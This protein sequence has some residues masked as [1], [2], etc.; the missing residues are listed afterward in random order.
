MAVPESVYVSV[1]CVCVRG[2]FVVLFEVLFEVL[3]DVLLEVFVHVFLSLAR[4]L[5]LLLPRYLVTT[6]QGR[7]VWGKKKVVRQVQE[8]V[9]SPYW[10][11][12]TFDNMQALPKTKTKTGSAADTSGR[13]VSF[14]EGR[15]V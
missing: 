7:D 13:G 10:R 3:L 11:D 15:D 9:A 1:F 8:E 6:L 5:S 12:V 2:V 14:L 4:P